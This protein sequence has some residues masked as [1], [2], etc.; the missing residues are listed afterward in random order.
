M[1]RRARVWRR[2]SDQHWYTTVNGRKVKVADKS[3]PYRRANQIFAER[4]GD[5]IAGGASVGKFFDKYLEFVKQN[6]SP[7]TFKWYKL[8]LRGLY[9]SL[10][11]GLIVDNLTPYH[12]QSWLDTKTEWNNNT[13]NAA[14]RGI[15]RAFNWG[16]KQRLIHRNPIEG[17]ERPPRTPRDV[18]ITPEQYQE[19]LDNVTDEEF[20]DYV[21]FLWETGCRAQEIRIIAKHHVE[22]NRIVFERLNSKGK[23][24]RR[25]IYLT[26]I[27]KTI[28]KRLCKRHP[29]GTLFRNAYGDPWTSNAVRGR[30]NRLSKRL[31][32]DD[33]CATV[34]RHSYCTRA[35]KQG[36][37][38]TTVAT[39]LG[40]R[41]TTM[42]ARVYQHLAKDDEYLLEAA[43]RATGSGNPAA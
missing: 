30:F 39:L 9:D 31:K 36:I 25:V 23:K 34:F 15:Y 24:D 33:L 27:A 43:Q 13:K 12:V 32:I 3:V 14:V 42:V 35:L 21:T 26:P 18:V 37:D 17:L 6:R 22:G 20:R 41:D 29:R 10:P 16:V 8:Y 28:I 5:S 11:R 1:G 40:H 38:T 4:F 19:I 7:G 2:Q